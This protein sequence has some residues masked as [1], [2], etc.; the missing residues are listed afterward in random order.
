MRGMKR[1]LLPLLGLL[2]IL[3]GVLAVVFLRPKPPLETKFVQPKRE[4]TEVEP[5]DS[6][7]FAQDKSAQG[8]TETESFNTAQGNAEGLKVEINQPGMKGE[9]TAGKHVYQ[10]FNNCGPA[11]LSMILAWYG[12]NVSQKELGDKMRPYQNPKG[13]NDDKTIFTHEFADWAQRYGLRSV[14]RVNGSIELLKLFIANDIPIVVKTWLRTN[15]DIGHFRIVRGFDESKQVIIQ[16]DSFEG[17]NKRFAYYD[18]LSM[19]QPFNFAYIIVYP[20]E[21]E[22]LVQAIIG[23]EWDETIAWR[24]A[25]ERAKQEE[26][27]APEN[28]YPIFNQSTSHYQLNEYQESVAAFERVE[29]RLPRRMLWY[30]IEPILAYQKLG[31]YERVFSI[32]DRILE[33]GN[34]AYAELYQIRGEVYLEQG[35]VEQ[36]REQFELALRYNPFFQPAIEA[37]EQLK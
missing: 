17:P 7:D 36:A 25:L 4:E 12:V 2:I 16:D 13:D 23:R 24:G 27:L 5:F 22:A 19:W 14:S 1:F 11:T 31:R 35:R 20:E 9:L 10:T 34:R 8:K 30:Q 18:F 28:V 32:T 29:A 33:S 3:G 37:L 6:F 26:E 21:K 15:E